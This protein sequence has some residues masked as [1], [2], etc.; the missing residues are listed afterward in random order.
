ML[1]N[2]PFSGFVN[3]WKDASAAALQ[4]SLDRL[5]D[6]TNFLGLADKPDTDPIQEPFTPPF[7]GGQCV[8]ALYRLSIKWTDSRGQIYAVFGG[9]NGAGGFSEPAE[10]TV[11]SSGAIVVGAISGIS[12]AVDIGGGVWRVTINGVTVQYF[13]TQPPSNFQISQ[14]YR[15][16]GGTDNCGDLPNPNP[17][18]PPAYGALVSENPDDG[19]GGELVYAGLPVLSVAGVLAA[20]R[21]IAEGIAVIGD[22]L[23]GIRQIGEAIKQISDLLKEIFDGKKDDDKAKPKYRRYA[24]GEWYRLS[25]IDGFIPATPITLGG[26][27]AIPYKVQIVVEEFPSTSSRVLGVS[28][29][30]ISIDTLPLFYLLLQEDD[31]GVTAVK[32]IRTLNSSTSIPPFHRGI[33]WN[34][35][36]NPSINA[37]YR[38]FYQTEQIEQEVEVQE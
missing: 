31:F 29:P 10:S 22:V 7:T 2:N 18:F 9:E 17:E 24:V 30:S 36:L 37:K 35:R 16:D 34:F 6:L 21:A 20:L 13:P 3:A 38:F 25:T 28:S 23:N 19:E 12:N 5:A 15:V 33:F 4:Y 11:R 14:I 26:V 27:E 1:D 8:G 32:P